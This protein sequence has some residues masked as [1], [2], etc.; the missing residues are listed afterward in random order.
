MSRRIKLTQ[1]YSTIVD[2]AD[3]AFLS[4]FKWF[5][6]ISDGGAP[7]AARATKR[8]DGA[9]TTV[10]MHRVILDVPVGLIVDH[11]NGD[12]L[13]NRRSNL[14]IATRQ[15]NQFNSGPTK[16]GASKFKGVYWSPPHKKW[17][18]QI[19]L[20]GVKKHLGLFVNEVDAAVAYEAVAKKH[21]GKFFR[22]SLHE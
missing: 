21:H 7:Y 18:A 9:K 6:W 16:K 19:T 8:A 5:A 3:Y 1:G 10:R 2:D 13:D 20:S 4:Q 14:R 22:S 15:Q 11:K 17:R 12:G